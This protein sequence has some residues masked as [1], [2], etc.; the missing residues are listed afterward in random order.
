M[1]YSS[2]PHT[3]QTMTSLSNTWLSLP[4]STFASEL[5]VC[6]N[7]YTPIHSTLIATLRRSYVESYI[8]DL[9]NKAGLET[10]RIQVHACNGVEGFTSYLFGPFNISMNEWINIAA[11]SY[12]PNGG[13]VAYLSDVVRSDKTSTVPYPPIHMHH[14]HT[15]QPDD[16]SWHRFETH[17][18]YFG[19]QSDGYSMTWPKGYCTVQ[20]TPVMHTDNPS[21]PSNPS[22]PSQYHQQF[23]DIQNGMV[24]TT[25]LINA[26]PDAYEMTSA[27][28][29]SNQS[30]ILTQPLYLRLAFRHVSLDHCVRVDKMLLMPF[31]MG[32]DD[33]LTRFTIDTTKKIV[34]WWNGR[35]PRSGQVVSM[36]RH[37][38]RQRDGGTIM[39]AGALTPHPFTIPTRN[40][41]QA[42]TITRLVEWINSTLGITPFAR[43]SLDHNGQFEWISP[44][45]TRYG[46]YYTVV[47]IFNSSHT[48]LKSHTIIFMLY[49][50]SKP[51][52]RLKYPDGGN[53]IS[54]VDG[55]FRT[56]DDHRSLMNDAPFC[57]RHWRLS[58]HEHVER[59][60]ETQFSDNLSWVP[61]GMVAR[62][63][64]NCP[65][66]IRVIFHSCDSDM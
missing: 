16:Y 1:S 26:V 33:P 36:W 30:L 62:G 3:T 8:L 66:D 19:I 39:L 38:H 27:T 6:Q 2:T 49:V 35:F 54:Q 64:L 58:E 24:Y 20:E 11:Y 15:K 55:T 59:S 31:M 53:G 10:Q 46:E 63:A 17:G 14:V 5:D 32:L 41:T 51:R 61:H 13:T 57:C 65:I 4:T 44:L 28:N 43:T 22:K 29:Q 45:M 9:S 56:M 23:E 7:Q 60:N 18:D 12:L 34:Y 25:S 40:F 21:N 48:L 50:P 37:A 47:S 52:E 42:F